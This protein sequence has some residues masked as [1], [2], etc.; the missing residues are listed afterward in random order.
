M[1]DYAKGDVLIELR[2]K[3]G[4][5]REKA[6]AE[7]GFTT[8]TLFTWEKENGGIRADNAKRLAEFYGVA[9]FSTLLTSTGDGGDQLDRIEAKLD[10]IMDHLE[11]RPLTPSEVADETERVMQQLADKQSQG[12]PAPRRRR[13]SA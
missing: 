3:S 2:K 1:A 8:K 7:L 6:A 13:R 5:T 11:I 9:D 4:L 12:E 10:A